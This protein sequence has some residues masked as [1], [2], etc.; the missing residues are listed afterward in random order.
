ME[1][2]VKHFS[3]MPTN[4]ESSFPDKFLV[5]SFHLLSTVQLQINLFRLF[6]CKWANL[7]TQ[8]ATLYLYLFLVCINFFLFVCFWSCTF[9]Y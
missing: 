2:C 5:R 1:T 9:F 6:L 3:I 7:N 4:I 8:A